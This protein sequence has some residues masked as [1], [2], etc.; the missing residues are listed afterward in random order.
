MTPD[1]QHFMQQLCAG[2]RGIHADGVI[3]Y[4]MVGH[5]AGLTEAETVAAI[6]ELAG[7]YVTHG[8]VSRAV[9][10]TDHGASWCWRGQPADDRARATDG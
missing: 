5:E 9:F 7:R 3:D 2:T 8:T 4:L 10:L 6:R 1:A